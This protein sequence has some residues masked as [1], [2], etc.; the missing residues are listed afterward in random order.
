M[1]H[2]WFLKFEEEATGRSLRK[3]GF[4]SIRVSS[5][6]DRLRVLFVLPRDGRLT[7]FGWIPTEVKEARWWKK[8]LFQKRDIPLA[9]K[10]VVDI[11][12]WDSEK[13]C[14]G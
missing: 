8:K 13:Q 14:H 12:P 4:C 11:E 3:S 6:D 10:Q 7:D 5:T 1:N 2:F 9:A